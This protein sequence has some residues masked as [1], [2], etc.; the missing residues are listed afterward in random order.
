MFNASKPQAQ[1]VPASPSDDSRATAARVAAENAAIADSKSAGRRS[2]V[3][4]GYEISANE[5]AAR[6]KKRAAAMLGD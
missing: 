6:V 1:P 5:Q 4:A 2:T 3:H